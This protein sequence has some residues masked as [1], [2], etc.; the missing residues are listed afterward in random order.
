MTDFVFPEDSGTGAY[1]TGQ[2]DDND[3]AN[4]AAYIEATGFTDYVVKGL[5]FTLDAGTPSLDVSKGK[6]VLT[7]DTVSAA[8]TNE[9]RDEG[10]SFVAEID[11]RTGLSL[12][13]NDVNHV[14]LDVDLSSKDA[15]SV[16]VNT[17]DSAPASPSLK[18]GTVDTTNDTTTELN[19]A[20]KVA[21]RIS[22]GNALENDGS[23]NVAVSTNGIGTDELDES[24]AFSFTNLG[25]TTITG[26][27]DMSNNNIDDVASIDGG[28]DAVI[29]NDNINAGGNEI[30]LGASSGTKFVY[31]TGSSGAYSLQVLDS[32][33]LGGFS[34]RAVR[35]QTAQGP[36]NQAIGF[37][38]GNQTGDDFLKID[39]SPGGNAVWIEN[40]ALNLQNNSISDLAGFDGGGNDIVVADDIALDSAGLFFN[41]SDDTRIRDFGSNLAFGL[42]GSRDLRVFT[43]DSGGN[44]VQ[45]LELEGGADTSR[46]V[47]ESTSLNLADSNSIQDS[48]ADMINPDGTGGFSVGGNLDMNTNSII[49]P[50]GSSGKLKAKDSG[51]TI[52]DLLEIDGADN[53]ILRDTN[54]TTGAARFLALSGGNT[55]IRN[56]SNTTILTVQSGGG[57]DINAA[58][59][60][61]PTNDS[62]D[63]SFDADNT[64]TAELADVLA[65][66]IKD[67]GLD[68]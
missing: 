39:S 57:I 23:G 4:F 27:L 58:N 15:V 12:T 22:L 5:N 51:G 36:G 37:V 28:G 49:L 17:T 42:D 68:S 65:T 1:A 19:R 33:D 60:F 38:F 21:D 46:L 20:S 53:T 29:F 56:G 45:R 30:S 8:Q 16:V 47:L 24:A 2:G 43:D 44:S 63:R 25:A 35:L 67:L 7:K 54:G 64:T 18:I 61:S 3:A 14:F 50:N 55:E 62:T 32:G 13:D 9:S 59:A 6:A 26:D 34:T 52:H 31:S 48:G 66:L 10:N 11:Q 41:T 40:G